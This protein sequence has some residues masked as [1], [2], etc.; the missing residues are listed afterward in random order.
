MVWK[1]VYLPPSTRIVA[2]IAEC[3]HAGCVRTAGFAARKEDAQSL[4]SDGVVTTLEVNK[5]GDD[6]DDILPEE[7]QEVIEE[8][9][10]FLKTQ[11]WVTSPVILCSIHAK[12]N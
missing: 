5:D 8:G 1:T 7:V 12:A 3:D 6:I 10:K 9:T 11:G 4:S 2:V